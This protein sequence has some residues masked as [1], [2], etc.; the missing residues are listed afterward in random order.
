[1]VGRRQTVHTR[2]AQFGQWLNTFW[3]VH[4]TVHRVRCETGRLV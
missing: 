4:R 3:T 2:R 1:M